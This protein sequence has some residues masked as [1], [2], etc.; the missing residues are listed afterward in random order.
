LSL[1]GGTVGILGVHGLAQ[2]P[3]TQ[4]QII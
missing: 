1:L 2:P 4:P 3:R